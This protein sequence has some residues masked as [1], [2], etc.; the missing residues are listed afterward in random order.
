MNTLRFLF[1]LVMISGISSGM[2]QAASDSTSRLG[3]DPPIVQPVESPDDLVGTFIAGVLLL[4][5]SE[6]G[7]YRLGYQPGWVVYGTYTVT[8]EAITFI[9]E[10]GPAACPGDQ[11]GSYGWTLSNGRLLIEVLEDECTLRT[12]LMTYTAFHRAGINSPWW[13]DLV[14]HPA[15]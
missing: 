14:D 4:E 10:E 7:K 12:T 9:D 5:L 3:D 1:I 15:N 2:V 6:D 8:D 13:E 11:A